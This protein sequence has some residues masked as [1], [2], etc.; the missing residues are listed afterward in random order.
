MYTI[1]L[2]DRGDL[3]DCQLISTK[4]DNLVVIDQGKY[5]LNWDHNT[6]VNINL[7]TH[8]PIKKIHVAQIQTRIK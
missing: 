3:Q 2:L 5:I 7:D 4:D 6:V 1:S 8:D